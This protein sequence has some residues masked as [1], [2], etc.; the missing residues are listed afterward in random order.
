MKRRALFHKAGRLIAG[1]A[2][3][4]ILPEMPVA[5][6]EPK[7]QTE[8]PTLSCGSVTVITG[9]VPYTECDGIVH[10][11]AIAEPFGAGDHTHTFCVGTAYCRVHNERCEGYQL[12]ERCWVT[13]PG[14]YSH[15]L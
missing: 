9:T 7:V 2:A 12:N 11:H 5:A 15:G 4:K 14:R 6:E 10:T 8:G 1:A 13:D 3:T